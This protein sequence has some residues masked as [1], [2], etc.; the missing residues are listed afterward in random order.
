M[1]ALKAHWKEALPE[2]RPLTE[3]R[4]PLPKARRF[5]AG[6]I[7]S[8][9]Q[10]VYLEFQTTWK[11]AGYFTI[12]LV[13]VDGGSEL[14]VATQ[15]HWTVGQRL[16]H[17]G[18]RI[19]SFLKTDDPQHRGHDKWWHLCEVED[20]AVGDGLDDYFREMRIRLREGD[21]TAPSYENETQV[22]SL[23]VADVTQDV[24]AALAMI[25]ILIE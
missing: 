4:G 21:W 22:L 18:H 5:D 11:R 14:S 8:T 17:E 6:V 13:V 10:H 24:K 19:G 3:R 2:I 9:G 12:N 20:R 1:K 23:A 16:S 25:G 7:P 15:F